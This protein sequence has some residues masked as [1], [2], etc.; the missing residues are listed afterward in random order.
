MNIAIVGA[1]NGGNKLLELFYNTKDVR[2]ILVVD[3]D[4]SSEG[5]IN[6]K[7]KNI[8][9][10]TELD[11]IENYSIDAIIEATGSTY[12]HDYLVEK[13]G[14]VKQIIDSSFASIM[15]D[16]VDKQTTV[17]DMLNVKIKTISNTTGVLDNEVKNIHDSCMTLGKVSNVLNDSLEESKEYILQSDEIIK[18]VNKIT[19]QIKILGLNANI[20]AAR[21]G[22]A[23]RGFSVVASEV[24]KLSDITSD[25]AMELS[26]LLDSISKVN[27]QITE[28]VKVL[29]SI[30]EKQKNLSDNV[31]SVVEELVRESK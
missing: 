15:M 14:Q 26:S 21:A 30:S 11:D 5:I 12:V 24:Q 2:V 18:S 13:Y 3:R 29:E 17:S 27:G 19:Q 22:E 20:E 4:F 1:G 31:E 8:N 28:E 16:I 23:G 10:G 7:S 6:A 9:T 25:F